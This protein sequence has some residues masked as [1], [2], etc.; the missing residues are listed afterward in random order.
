MIKTNIF[1][2]TRVYSYKT[3]TGQRDRIVIVNYKFT[4]RN[5]FTHSDD[6][7]SHDRL[8]RRDPLTFQ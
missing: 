6:D 8:L 5:S 1:D 7:L 2:E 3:T 4:S